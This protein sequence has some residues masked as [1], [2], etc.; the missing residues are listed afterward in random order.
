MSAKFAQRRGGIR[1]GFVSPNPITA[2]SLRPA[3]RIAEIAE[4]LAAGL[5]RLRA[6]KSSSFSAHAGEIFVD[7]A[8][9]QSGHAAHLEN[10]GDG[11]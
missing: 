8:A 1:G 10:E 3:E 6:R 7:C 11:P 4:I 2:A 9:D 5:V